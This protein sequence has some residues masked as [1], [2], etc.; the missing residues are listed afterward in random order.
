M[1][2]LKKYRVLRPIGLSGRVEAGE[3]VS[4]DDETAAAYAPGF[5]EAVVET[6]PAAPA[7]TDS[8]TAGDQTADT[9]T[10]SDTGTASDQQGDATSVAADAVGEAVGIEGQVAANGE[11]TGDQT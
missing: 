5:L 4:L 3:I 8:G 1:S 6:A 10:G 2:E 11:T 9:A 7:P